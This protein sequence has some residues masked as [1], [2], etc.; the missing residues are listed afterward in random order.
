[1]TNLEKIY[2]N[3]KTVTTSGTPVQLDAFSVPAGASLVI[4]GLRTN[5]GVITVGYSSS[6]ALNSGTSHTTLLANQAKGFQ[7]ENANAIWIDATV[8]GEG[9]EIFCESNN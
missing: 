4:Q 5:T 8:S 2:T 1:M 6:S 3:Q 7:V 9:V